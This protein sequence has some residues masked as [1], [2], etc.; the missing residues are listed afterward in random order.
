MIGNNYIGRNCIGHNYL[1]VVRLVLGGIDHPAN[2]EAVEHVGRR[3]KA[4]GA[5]EQPFAH[6]SSYGV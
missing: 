1:E 4:C 6:L 3:R 2:T 5:D